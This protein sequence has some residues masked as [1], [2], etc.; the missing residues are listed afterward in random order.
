MVPPNNLI[1]KPD[2]AE[3]LINTILNGL[4]Q[5]NQVIVDNMHEFKETLNNTITNSLKKMSNSLNGELGNVINDNKKKITKN[6]K[7]LMKNKR[8]NQMNKKVLYIFFFHLV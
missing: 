1:L 7:L 3:R 8:R 2:N 6:K 5:N 4:Q